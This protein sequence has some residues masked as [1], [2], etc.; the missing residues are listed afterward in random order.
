MPGLAEGRAEAEHVDGGEDNDR[1]QGIGGEGPERYCAHRGGEE[2]PVGGGDGDIRPLS[3]S[4]Q[5]DEDGDA[6]RDAG[7]PGPCAAAVR[8]LGEEDHEGGDAPD[9]P[10]EDV[11]P[12]RAAQD[13]A[14][15]GE[16]RRQRQR[17][18]DG[19]QPLLDHRS[20]TP[21]FAAVR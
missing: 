7:R 1:P 10:G 6:C 15:I 12:D 19:A 5:R 18:G 17:D 4:Q 3:P 14:D 8:E 13:G 2:Q 9:H 20:P 11:R 21:S 16:K